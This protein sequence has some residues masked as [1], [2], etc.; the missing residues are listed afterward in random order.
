[1]LDYS[2]YISLG[3]DHRDSDSYFQVEVENGITLNESRVD[4]MPVYRKDWNELT[5]KNKPYL[6]KSDATDKNKLYDLILDNEPNTT[7]FVKLVY[8]TDIVYGYFGQVDC[9]INE[10]KTLIKIKPAVI[11]AYT[12]FIENYDTDIDIFGQA[13]LIKN[14]DFKVWTDG[15]PD[16]WSGINAA[17]AKLL[18]KPCAKLGDYNFMT[19][20]PLYDFIQGR[21]EQSFNVIQGRMGLFEFY[22][23]LLG[24]VEYRYN[25]EYRVK[26]QESQYSTPVYYLQLDGSWKTDSS[27]LSYHTNKLPVSLDYAESEG[28]RRKT[29]VT[30]EMPI[31][32]TV[33]IEFYFREPEGHVYTE[34]EMSYL[35]I[36]DVGFYSSNIQY[37]DVKI[38]L[39]SDTLIEKLQHEIIKPSGD[40]ILKWLIANPKDSEVK[41][42]IDYFNEDGSPNMTLLDDWT[43]GPHEEDGQE[44]RQY[45]DYVSLFENNADSPF[46]KAE[47][48]EL[49]IYKGTR[50]RNSFLEAWRRHIKGVAKFAREEFY[51]EDEY[52]ELDELIPPQE[53]AGWYAT[54]TV[55]SGKRLWVRTPYNGAYSGENATWELGDLDSTGGTYNGFDWIERITSKKVYPTGDNSK[56]ISTGVSFRDICRKIYRS[57]HNSRLDKEVYS[58]FFWNDSPYLD[59]LKVTTDNYHTKEDNELNNIAAIHTT[60]LSTELNVNEDKSKLEVSFKNFF[61]DLK[62]KF[63]FLIWFIDDDLNLH[64]EHIKFIDMTEDFLNILTPDYSYVGE[65]ENYE[66]DPNEIF[67]TYEYNEINSGYKDFK[68]SKITFDKIVSNKRNKDLKKEITAKYISTDIQYAIE[69]PNSLENGMILVAYDAGDENIVKYGSGQITGNLM[70]NGDLSI[71]TLLRRYANYEGVWTRGYINDELVRFPYTKKVKKGDVFTLKGIITDRFFLTALGIATTDTKEY[72]FDRGT[73]KV[74]PI[75]RHFDYFLVMEQDDLIE[76]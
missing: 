27:I 11:D 48:S 54:D 52:D 2:L 3:D 58:A 72:D 15:M 10:N 38:N 42:L 7:F 30:K 36:T 49:S 63:P 71:S 32:G 8:G 61:E 25:L 44:E 12:D 19:D 39:F 21:I 62:V 75:Y 69:N 26:L 31:S 28:F 74:T 34:S 64:I 41:P 18:D 45:P 66:F 40:Y 67:G 4:G 65:Y 59:E 9:K 60:D 6:Y 55:T 56:S 73:T 5:I 35:Y 20:P 17:R 57:T 1:M 22:Y 33:T 13:N 47:I 46:Y 53:D 76:L 24:D 50:W 43:H 23:F 68:S 51:K 14:G 29:I 16:D 70:P 37:I